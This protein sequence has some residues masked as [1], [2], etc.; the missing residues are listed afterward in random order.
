[1]CRIKVKLFLCI[2]CLLLAWPPI[3]CSAAVTLSDEEASRIQQIVSESRQTLRVSIL[4]L[5]ESQ[6][7][8][9]QVSRELDE[10][11]KELAEV[12]ALLV[13]ASLVLGQTQTDLQQ[14]NKDLEKLSQ[15]YKEKVSSLRR[16]RTLNYILEG[17]LIVGFGYAYSHR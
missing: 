2:V 6:K 3:S 13:K 12:K 15:S 5:T 17:L 4:S 8:L 14:S 16:D 11:R 9:I 1:M 7:Q 10:S